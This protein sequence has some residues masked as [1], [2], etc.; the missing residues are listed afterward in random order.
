LGVS[1]DEKFRHDYI[2]KVAPGG[3]TIKGE[4][5]KIITVDP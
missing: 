2:K 3:A 5:I 4:N 1:P